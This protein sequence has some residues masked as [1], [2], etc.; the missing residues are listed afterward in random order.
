MPLPYWQQRDVLRLLLADVELRVADGRLGFEVAIG[1]L[2]ELIALPPSCPEGWN[3]IQ[4]Q[5]A[6]IPTD[7]SQ[8][9]LYLSPEQ[10]RGGGEMGGAILARLQ[11]SR[12][13]PLA[14]DAYD[15]Y[16]ADFSRIPRSWE[17]KPGEWR[18]VAFARTKFCDSDGRV[19][20]RAL[21]CNG[22]RWYRHFGRLEDY[23]DARH[24]VAVL[25]RS[26][27]QSRGL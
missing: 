20:V 18:F 2:R 25:A 23:W 12:E 3:I 24:F 27:P 8:V 4:H 10:K 13:P 16:A 15:Y 26:S 11:S 9:E 17:V 14:A 21:C 5:S 22:G 1:K 7:G 6:G 19:C